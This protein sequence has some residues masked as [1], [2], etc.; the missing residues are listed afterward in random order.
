MD[1]VPCCLLSL[2]RKKILLCLIQN[3]HC[4]HL[5]RILIYALSCHLNLYVLHAKGGCK[6][7]N[8]WAIFLRVTV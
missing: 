7:Q 2:F 8:E 6:G 4:T 5:Y 1:L 3:S